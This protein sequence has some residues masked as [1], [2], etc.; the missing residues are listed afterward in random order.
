MDNQRKTIIIQE[1]LY[2]KENSL[3]P[4]TYCD[5][6][7]ALYTGGDENQASSESA[8]EKKRPAYRE[9]LISTLLSLV[10]ITISLLVIY[11]TKLSYLLQMTIVGVLFISTSVLIVKSSSKYHRIVPLGAGAIL[12]LLMSIHTAQT[13]MPGQQLVLGFT[14]LLNSLLWIFVGLKWKMK[15]F[16]F[17]SA[18]AVILFAVKFFV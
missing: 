7:L 6:L 18:I 14:I 13:F 4:N 16:L 8:N 1:I 10:F 11:F 15:S 17:S 5:F 12:L 2:W 3:L 9:K